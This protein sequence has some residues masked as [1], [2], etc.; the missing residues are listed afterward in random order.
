MS[1][2][3]SFVFVA[4]FSLLTLFLIVSIVREVRARLKAGPIRFRL[5]LASVAKPP[6]AVKVNSV[7]LII[8]VFLLL[9]GLIFSKEPSAW[10]LPTLFL[11]LVANNLQS[12]DTRRDARG[13]L[14]LTSGLLALMLGAMLLT[15]GSRILRPGDALY[16]MPA[17]FPY[18]WA[19]SLLV[20]D[21]LAIQEFVSGTRVR[22]GGIE[23]FGTT[24]P[25]SRVVVK[26]WQEREGGSALRLSI[27]PLLQRETPTG[28]ESEIIVPVPASERPAL[29]DFLKGGV[30][31]AG[32][33]RVGE[34][35][36]RIPEMSPT[37]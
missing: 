22:E 34:D 7:I 9:P 32:A 33:S 29:E 21:V 15:F 19:V 28:P 36:G 23:M 4:L 11:W 25:W 2:W 35:L 37:E 24:R 26:G 27:V 16:G 12:I 30:A 13:W 14:V 20:P 1:S 18:F 10:V 5:P 8:S 6:R 17:W 3:Y 31:N